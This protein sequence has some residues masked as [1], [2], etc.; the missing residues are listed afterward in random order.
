MCK[1]DFKDDKYY[2]YHSYF[3]NT[4]LQIC[5][6]CAIREYYGS[7]YAK[8]KKWKKDKEKNWLFGKPSTRD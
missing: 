4:T 2:E 6:K 3:S 1:V 7:K 5:Y 8:G